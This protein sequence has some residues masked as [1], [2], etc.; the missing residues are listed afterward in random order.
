VAGAAAGLAD[1]WLVAASLGATWLATGRVPERVKAI[2]IAAA[3]AC[4]RNLLIIAA[5]APNSVKKA[6]GLAPQRA[7]ARP[8]YS[9]S[10]AGFQTS[11]PNAAPIF[12]G[13]ARKSR[14]SCPPHFTTESFP[15]GSGGAKR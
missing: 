4:K 3:M 13:V 15:N 1:A 9:R 2:A 11:C 12:G 7:R 6:P 10:E 8:I 14:E 5:N